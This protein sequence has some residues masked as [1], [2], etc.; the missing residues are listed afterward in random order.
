MNTAKF[1]NPEGEV[2]EVPAHEAE[3]FDALGWQR[4]DGE[5]KPK[6]KGKK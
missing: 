6:I 4:D 1:I 2:V 3:Q 5:A